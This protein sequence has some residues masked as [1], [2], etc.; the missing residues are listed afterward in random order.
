M[1][2]AGFLV[3]ILGSFHC[4]GMCGPI[5]LALPTSGG[6]AWSAW[7][8]RLAYNAGRVTTYAALGAL[9]GLLGQGLSLAGPQQYVSIG[10][11]ALM[12][13]LALIPN[14]RLNGFNPLARLTGRVKQ[15]LGKLFQQRS[16]GSL[17]LLGVLN[18]LLPCGLVY[19]AL[20]GAIATG[21]VLGGAAYMALFGLGTVPALLTL[22]LAGHLIRPTWR[23]RLYR[24]VPVVVGVMGVM[25][26]VRGLNLGIPYLSPELQTGQPVERTFN[27]CHAPEE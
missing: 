12:L 3:G 2:W 4:L 22:S 19:V 26:I 17:Y 23:Q 16:A 11:G 27:C 1:V 9:L 5:A 21:H 14:H 10:A 24:L 13:L 6:A 8:T 18:G 7:V 25:L 20:A 15:G